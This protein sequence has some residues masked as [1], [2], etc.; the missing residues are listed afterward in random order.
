M[1]YISNKLT[2]WVGKNKPPEEQYNILT[3]NILKEKE[4]RFGKC[5]WNFGTKD[6]IIKN[7]MINMII[8]ICI[9]NRNMVYWFH[10]TTWNPNRA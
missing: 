7:H 10:E 6:I 3:Q 4:L 5:E 2:H 8:D 1:A 9:S